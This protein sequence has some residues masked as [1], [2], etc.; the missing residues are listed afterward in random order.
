MAQIPEK[1]SLDGIE[2][3]WIDRWEAD[4]TYR[5]DRSGDPRPGVR[6]RHAAAHRERLAARR[7]R[8]LLHPHRHRRPLPAH[9]RRAA[10]STRSAGTTTASPPSAGCR[11]TS[12]C[13]ATRRS[14]YDPD[15][16]APAKPDPKNQVP[17]SRPNFVEL[18]ERLVADDEVAFE[19][20]FRRLGLSRRLALPLHDHRRADDPHA[21][22]SV[23]FLRNLRPRRGL[24]A[25]GAD[26]VGRRLPHRGRPG[27]A[28]GPGACPAPTTRSPFHRADGE[29]TSSSTPPGPSCWPRAC[30][31]VAHPDDERYQPLFGTTVRT[32]LFGVEVP[33]LAHPL[34]E[35]DKGTGIAMICTFG[36][37]HRRHLVA[38]AAT[39][40]PA[41]IVGR[42]GRI[43]RRHTRVDHRARGP[44]PLRRAGRAARS[45][46]P[47]PAS[48]SCCG[49]TGELQG[50]PR[51]ITHPVK[52]YEKG[53]RPLE[54]VTT[55]A[56]VHPQRRPRPAV[57]RVA[58]R[59]RRAAA[60]GTPTTCATATRTGWRA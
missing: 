4:G 40:R 13:A 7:P 28:G 34:A 59:A 10:S 26:A 32:P 24:P 39:C 23:A 12:A 30:A 42:D 36:D 16:Q 54:I 22:A 46:R 44:R 29:A 56:V 9:A 45:S 17:V 48:S 43:A 8:V 38:R 53:D 20:L 27:R 19:A 57:A 55:P 15:F 49:E 1:P 14:P 33:V 58:A 3:R 25:G 37:T 6:H 52:F 50:E 21:S 47:R 2:A 11:T 5:F 41:P 60:A 51:P 35:P 31:L 18:C